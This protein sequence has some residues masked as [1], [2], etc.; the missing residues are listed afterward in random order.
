MRIRWR[1]RNKTDNKLEP[2]Q[3][4]VPIKNQDSKRFTEN[5]NTVNTIFK[6]CPSCS[7]K[8]LKTENGCD[9]CMDCGYSKCDK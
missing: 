2:E 7:E 1:K 3:E 4:L 6:I 5:T 8:G 9:T